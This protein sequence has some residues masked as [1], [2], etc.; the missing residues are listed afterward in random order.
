MKIEEKQMKRKEK[1]TQPSFQTHH[2]LKQPL[3]Y[4]YIYGPYHQREQL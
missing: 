2:E 3:V 4:V 1:E